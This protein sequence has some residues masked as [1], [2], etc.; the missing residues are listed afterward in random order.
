MESYITIKTKLQFFLLFCV[1]AMTTQAQGP[2]KSPLLNIGDP[3]P[4]IRVQSWIK[5]PPVQRFEKGK[6]YVVDFWATWCRPCIASMPR[7]SDLAHQYKDHVTFLAI[8]IWEDRNGHKASIPKIISFVDSMD[9]RMNFQVAM[10][11]GNFMLHHW[12]KAFDE[13]GIP[14]DFVVDAAGRVAWIGNPE[15][16]DSVLLKIVNNT[17]EIKRASAE[18]IF[19]RH[20]KEL[21]LAAGDKLSNYLGDIDSLGSA[22][23]TKPDSVLEVV[24]DMVKREPKLKYAPRVASFTFW[25]LLK[26]DQEKAYEYGKKVIVTPTYTKPACYVIIGKIDYLSSIIK[27]KKIYRLGAEAYQAEIDHTSPVYRKLLDLFEMYQK[28]GTWYRLA[29]DTVKAKEVDRKAV[30]W[31]SH[32]KK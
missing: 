10:D 13:S 15:Y 14:T 17:W 18:R 7:L 5:G 31:E 27:N 26:T 28:M 11:D 32:L 3:A 19:N 30:Q 29:Q 23:L 6:V 8:D 20:L 4:P 21:D 25:A 2:I 1:L 24:N 16:L 9:S 12:I 22:H